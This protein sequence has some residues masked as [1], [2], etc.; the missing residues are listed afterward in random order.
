MTSKRANS[1]TE[2][3]QFS[4]IAA[5]LLAWYDDHHRDL[6]WRT[7]PARRR[8]G[9]RP[10]PYHVW[11]SEIMLQQT[12]VEAVKPYYNAFLAR[13]PDMEAL[14]SA[15][16][17]D[18]MKAW[19]GLGYYSRARNLKRCAER[20]TRDFA[21][22]LPDDMEAL[23][24]LPGIGEYTAAAIA[25]IA[26]DRKA[27]V[28][29]GNVE[30]V[31]ARQMAIGEPMRSAKKNVRRIVGQLTPGERPGDFAQAMMD[32]GALVCTPKRPDC[33][34]CPIRDGCAA[35]ETGD[36]GRFPARTVKGEK[37]L[38]RAAA[39]VAV[40]GDGAILLR[41]R[42]P[43]GLLA[44]MSEVPTSGFTARADGDTSET[45]APFR[46]AWRR[47]G[48]AVHAFTHF[49]LE[50]VTYRCDSPPAAPG[51]NCWWAPAGTIGQEALPTVMRKA[52]AAAGI[53]I[54]PRNTEPPRGKSSP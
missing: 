46:G 42:P 26:F 30:R 23:R 3:P 13:W 10:A 1:K 12:T 6:P 40:R 17:E 15:D 5:R 19:A 32:L 28:V 39:F 14:A 11:L 54:G 37:P 35:F 20:V 51:G 34:R 49:R 22:S 21:G 41:K 48:I 4:T 16:M 43:N 47:T 7:S 45:G 52:I 38:R 53:D 44:G 8:N 18:V 25:A 33:R 36:P 24:A 50:L 9:A 31:V 2:L 27:A 29:D